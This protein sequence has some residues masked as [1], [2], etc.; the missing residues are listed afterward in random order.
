MGISI[1]IIEKL[2]R[3]QVNIKEVAI[4]CSYDNNNSSLNPRAV[5]HGFG[6]AIFVLKMRV[7]NRSWGK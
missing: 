2:R 4:T 1:E 7:F 6:V 5:S 3:M